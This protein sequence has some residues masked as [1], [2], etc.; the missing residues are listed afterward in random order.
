MAQAAAKQRVRQ[1]LEDRKR[2]E[3]VVRFLVNGVPFDIFRTTLRMH[4]G[5][6]TYFAALGEE[7]DTVYAATRAKVEFVGDDLPVADGSPLRP[8]RPKKELGTVYSGQKAYSV[9]SHLVEGDVRAFR[10]VHNYLRTGEMV[11]PD[12]LETLR[13]LATAAD[14]YQLECAGLVR[15]LVRTAA[16]DATALA[17]AVPQLDRHFGSVVRNVDNIGVLVVPRLDAIARAVELMR[18]AVEGSTGGLGLGGGG[19]GGDFTLF[20]HDE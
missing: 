7:L 12:D 16:R 19:L 11:A 15:G 13:L 5:L 6:S 18:R 8:A 1:Y 2:E 17:E 10:C 3:Y 9:L 14:M 4:R 20:E